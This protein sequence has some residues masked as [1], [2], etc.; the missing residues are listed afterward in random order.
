VLGRTVGGC[1]KRAVVGLLPVLA[2]VLVACGGGGSG[3]GSGG[4]G[5]AVTVK[6]VEY[7]RFRDLGGGSAYPVVRISLEVHNKTKQAARFT[8]GE[9]AV[10]AT[11]HDTYGPESFDNSIGSEQFCAQEGVTLQ[12]GEK[13]TLP[14]PVCYQLDNSNVRALTLGVASGEFCSKDE[15][16]EIKLPEGK[17]SPDLVP[18]PRTIASPA[19][20]ETRPP[21]TVAATTPTTAARSTTTRGPRFELSQTSVRAGDEIT[22]IG[23]DFLVNSVNVSASP[24]I[25]FRWRSADGPVLAE[26][27]PD[28]IGMTS[29]RIPIPWDARPG[30]HSI[31]ATQILAS[32]SSYLGTPVEV[33]ITVL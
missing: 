15:G 3:G 18:T 24:P 30:A 2:S 32:G 27:R 17:T 33:P 13:L 16:C 23:Y 5:A 25:H 10:T 11:D 28:K 9:T 4:G 14:Q 22:V 19:T 1:R 7:T 6:S 12:A 31:V 20:V 26:A 8:L 21:T 29:A